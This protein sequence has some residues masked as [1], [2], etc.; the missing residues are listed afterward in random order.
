MKVGDTRS[1]AAMVLISTSDEMERGR[2]A[3]RHHRCGHVV[4]CRETDGVWRI[5]RVERPD[6]DA[7]QP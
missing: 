3:L 2:V 6:A 5:T 7:V 1:A 4:I